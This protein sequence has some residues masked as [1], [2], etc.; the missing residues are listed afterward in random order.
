LVVDAIKLGTE[1]DS[2]KL[3]SVKES[4]Y[5]EGFE[6]D[7]SD[8]QANDQCGISKVEVVDG[9][10]DVW[11]SPG[12]D[13]NINIMIQASKTMTVKVRATTKGGKVGEREIEININPEA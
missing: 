9:G 10:N 3:F 4:D 7:F 6:L 1:D 5:F 12:H 8:P 11:I 2:N 13:L